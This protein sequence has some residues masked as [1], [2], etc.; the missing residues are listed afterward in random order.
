M[1][2][3]ALLRCLQSHANRG[4]WREWERIEKG[5]TQHD[6]WARE[7]NCRSGHISFM[8]VNT[9]IHSKFWYAFECY[10]GCIMIS[11]FLFVFNSNYK[12]S[13]RKSRINIYSHARI[14]RTAFRRAAYCG[15]Y[16]S[17]SVICMIS[18]SIFICPAEY[19]LGNHPCIVEERSVFVFVCS[20]DEHNE[21]IVTYKQPVNLFT[22]CNYAGYYRNKYLFIIGDA[23][24]LDDMD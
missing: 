3:Y 14:S 18:F 15:T 24:L 6:E 23:F 10:I 20:N 11:Y 17:K 22:T 19:I 16:R 13:F 12:I 7:R 21:Q 1:I 4:K 8:C 2:I 9:D 5:S